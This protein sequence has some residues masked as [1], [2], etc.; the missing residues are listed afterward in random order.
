L[1]HCEGAGLE[2]AERNDGDH[3]SQPRFELRT[4]GST[5]PIGKIA[6]IAG[7]LEAEKTG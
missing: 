5:N 4:Q 1:T 6:K 7:P 2:A 3:F